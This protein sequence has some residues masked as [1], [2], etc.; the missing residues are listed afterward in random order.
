MSVSSLKSVEWHTYLG[1]IVK[2]IGHSEFPVSL[3]ETIKEITPFDQCLIAAFKDQHGPI[4]VFD[5]LIEERKATTLS[6]YFKGAYLL[7]PFYGLV[8]DKCGDGVFELKEI[9]PD[10][11]YQTH[12][13]K[14]YYH[15]TR[16]M[17]ELA[18]F[19]NYDNLTIVISLGI[20]LSGSPHKER[21][22]DRLRRA[23][24]VIAEAVRKHMEI[25][26]ITNQQEEFGAITIGPSLD[27]GFQN[28]ATDHL[29]LRE[30]EITK[31]VLK[32]HSS[33]AI[34]R[35]L[36]ISPDTVKVHRKNI[37][38]KLNISSQSELFSLFLDALSLVKMDSSDDPLTLLMN[39]RN[40]A[41]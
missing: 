35:L 16:L 26:R 20:R 25:S 6:P 14:T 24:P 7:D 17:E 28:F 13:Y 40:Q 30:C 1:N 41:Y 21:D 12:Y 34:A 4:H 19:I 9:A 29:S 37:H 11:F 38:T 15:G 3:C 36:D 5:D 32:G 31:L 18:L 8:Q 27:T 23:F 39:Q 33:K 2:Y 10:E 22:L